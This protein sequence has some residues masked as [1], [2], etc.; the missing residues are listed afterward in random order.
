MQIINIVDIINLA[1]RI[2]DN[3][4]YAVISTW[5]R[6]NPRGYLKPK[7]YSYYEKGQQIQRYR[8]FEIL[9]LDISKVNFIIMNSAWMGPNTVLKQLILSMLKPLYPI[10]IVILRTVSPNGNHDNIIAIALTEKNNI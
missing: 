8:K 1:T 10:T 5:V 4:E 3:I 7:E 9:V 2:K 6:K